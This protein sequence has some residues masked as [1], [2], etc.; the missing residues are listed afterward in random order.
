MMRNSTSFVPVSF[1][2]SV[3]PF[4]PPLSSL[5]LSLSLSLSIPPFEL[6]LALCASYGLCLTRHTKPS[7]AELNGNS[8]TLVLVATRPARLME[9]DSDDED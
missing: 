8:F 3:C 7:D 6:R 2:P 1:S 9:D 5:S 4:V